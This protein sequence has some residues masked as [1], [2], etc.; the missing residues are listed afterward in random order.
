MLGL[1]KDFTVEVPRAL[2]MLLKKPRDTDSTWPKRQLPSRMGLLGHLPLELRIQIYQHLL[3]KPL[4]QYIPEP[5]L[6][7]CTQ[8][9]MVVHYPGLDNLD[10]TILRT[11]KDI[12]H[13]APPMLYFDNL[14]H[15]ERPDDIERF[16]HYGL[17]SPPFPSL[18]FAG[19]PAGPYGRL[20]LIREL[21]MDICPIASPQ[22]VVD[23]EQIWSDLGGFF[24]HPDHSRPYLDFPALT[25]LFLGFYDWDL[26]EETDSQIRVRVIPLSV[27]SQGYSPNL[28][29]YQGRAICKKIPSVRRPGRSWN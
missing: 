28:I 13:E 9:I 3:V 29:S 17:A 21:E 12:Y 18:S 2:P 22:D 14:F 7:L 24:N 1:H 19:L 27:T 6:R 26:D 20:A 23:R 10:S 16:G 5:H 11:C 15:F 4:D 25:D 8:K